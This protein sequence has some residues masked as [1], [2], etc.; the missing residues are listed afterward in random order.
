MVMD[1]K[2]LRL[3]VV[4]H[5]RARC[6][7]SFSLSMPYDHDKLKFIGQLPGARSLL[8]LPTNMA[9]SAGYLLCANKNSARKALNQRMLRNF[10][11]LSVIRN[12][13]HGG[14]SISA[15]SVENHCWCAMTWN[16]HK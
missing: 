4:C 5:P 12:T 8:Q 10:N 2:I 1:D 14:C 9:S 13:R 7:I 6:P 16:G 15:A 3:L 11:A